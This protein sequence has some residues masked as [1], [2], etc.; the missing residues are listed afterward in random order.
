M[1]TEQGFTFV[2]LFAGIGGLRV[3]FEATGGRCVLTAERDKYARRTYEAFFG[4][5]HAD[6]LFLNDINEA[7]AAPAAGEASRLKEVDEP[8]GIPRHDL[9]AAGFPC[10]P[11]SLAGVSKKNALG[12]A[13]GFADPTQGTLFFNLKEILRTRRPR[14][15]LLENVKNL[16]SHDRGNTWKVISD[17]LEEIGYAFSERV[18]DA[19]TVVPQHR[20]RVFIVGV[21]RQ[22]YGEL[23]PTPT[24]WAAFWEAVQAGITAASRSEQRRYRAQKWPKL[25]PILE[26]DPGERYTLTPHLWEYLQAYRAKHE[27]KGNGFGFSVFDASAARTRTISAR[28]H[29]DGSEALI[30]RGAGER[31]RRLT[32]L[33]CLRL[34]GFPAAFERH[35]DRTLVVPVSDTQAYRQFGNSVCVPLVKAIAVELVALMRRLEVA[36]IPRLPLRY[37]GTTAA[38]MGPSDRTA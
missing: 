3:A 15:F 37:P 30:S 22:R 10:Q 11:F 8:S 28:Y 4:P 1:A 21:D 23:S 5:S 26:S 38:S 7:F 25:G 12:R 35:F 14:A 34:Q 17:S 9:L 2:D 33:E 20:E 24:G 27:A 19:G 16:K 31:P 18:L 6:H 29:K 32:P 36:S 13:H